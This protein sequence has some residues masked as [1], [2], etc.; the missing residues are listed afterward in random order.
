MR[1][2]AGCKTHAERLCFNRH[3][4]DP[5]D[6]VQQDRVF[7]KSPRGAISHFCVVFFGISDFF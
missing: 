5:A 2:I 3:I 1:G 6:S 4:P 7:L